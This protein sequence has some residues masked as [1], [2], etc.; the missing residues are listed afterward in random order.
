MLK[1]LI[2]VQNFFRVENIKAD[3]VEKIS[4]LRSDEKGASLVE[5]SILIGLI[6]AAVIA[7]IIVV[8]TWIQGAWNTLTTNLGTPPA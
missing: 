6:A 5:Y 2:R 3:I 1:S 8:G 7:A 4:E